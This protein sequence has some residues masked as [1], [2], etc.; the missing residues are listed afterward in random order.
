MITI[1]HSHVTGTVV[2]GATRHDGTGPVFFA[3]DRQGGRRYHI[4]LIESA[5]PDGKAEILGEGDTR[6]GRTTLRIKAMYRNTAC[7]IKCS[8]RRPR[9]KVEGLSAFAARSART[10]LTLG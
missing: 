7:T 10:W 2:L 4:P 9:L 6:T 3:V 5:C 8:R 1:E